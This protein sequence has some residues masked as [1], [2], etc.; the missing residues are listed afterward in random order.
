MNKEPKITPYITADAKLMIWR[1]KM[2]GKGFTDEEYK[3]FEEDVFRGFL[4]EDVAKTLQKSKEVQ[5]ET[6][7]I[8][9]Q[10]KGDSRKASRYFLLTVLVAIGS[11]LL[12]IA[13]HLSG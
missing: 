4:S 6:I 7:S 3:Q 11:M 12:S 9:N 5:T 13:I 10:V 1:K 8:S 2:T